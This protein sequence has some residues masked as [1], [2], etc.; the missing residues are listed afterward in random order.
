VNRA[1]LAL[2]AV[3]P[4][5]AT[6]QPIAPQD[7]PTVLNPGAQGNQAPAPA[8]APGPRSQGSGVVV[9][10]PDGKVVTSEAGGDP[11]GYYVPP[12]GAGGGD[13]YQTPDTLHA[14]PVPELHVVRTG[15]TLWD[16]CSFYFNDPWQWPKIWSYNA[17]I[18]NPHWIYPGDLVRLLPRGMFSQVTPDP[19]EKG[20]DVK[21]TD[22]VPAPQRRIESTVKNTAFVEKS[23][24]DK[25]ITVDGAVDEKVLLGPGDELYLSYPEGKPPQVGKTYSIYVPGRAV[26][27]GSGD[28]GSYVKVLGTL[29]VLSVK[30]DKRARGVIVEATQEIERGVKVG[31]LVTRFNNVPFVASKVDL[32]GT[33]VAMLTKDQLIGDGE[34][35]FINVGKGSGIEVGNRMFVVRRGD[36]YPDVMSTE[37]GSDD[38]RFPARALGQIVVVAV[39]AKISIG[40]IT[41][42]IQEMSVG[43][44]VMMQKP[45]SK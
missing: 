42:S 29:R 37:I 20:P 44:L 24:L 30:Q 45:T 3:A 35:V 41:L 34:V 26:K 17:Q 25:S 5:A 27:S 18:T 23:D 9:V 39:G 4:A 43:D 6:A 13:T 19:G 11:G 16:I 40:V 12:G 15:D 21:P 8:P 1:V 22:P 14:G 10:G 36:A 38:R 31:P 2:A 28:Y 33:I 32:Q 7:A